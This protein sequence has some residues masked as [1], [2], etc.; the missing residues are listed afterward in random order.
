MA[1]SFRENIEF[2]I[3]E[4]VNNT[5]EKISFLFAEHCASGPVG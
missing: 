5:V 3:P 1:V 4:F 2:E